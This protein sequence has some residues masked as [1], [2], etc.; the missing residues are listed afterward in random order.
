[1]SAVSG[2]GVRSESGEARGAISRLAPAR[3]V[4]VP[5]P[6]GSGLM[7]RALLPE[8]RAEY[9]RVVR[10]SREHLERFSPL[11]LSGESDEA[12]F[13][14]Q[15]ELAR[16]GDARG[17]AWRRVAVLPDGRIAGAFN[18]NTIRRGLTLEGDANWWVAV[19]QV[20]RGIGT[21]GVRELVAHAFG[22]LPSGLGL[23]VLRAGIQRGNEASR[24]VAERAGF[25]LRAEGRTYLHAGG[26]GD[27][28]DEF[29]VALPRGGG[30]ALTAC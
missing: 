15:R 19:D 16:Q 1:M 27:L 6:G 7:L 21:E 2:R 3:P 17:T 10:L 18:V 9:V 30:G 14:R 13:E 22:E 26:R 28:G 23:H 20:R 11:H 4:R 25:R 29:E 12:L 8:D 5:G 24:R